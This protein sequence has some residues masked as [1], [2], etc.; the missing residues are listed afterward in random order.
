MS[1][2]NMEITSSELVTNLHNM[3]KL[4]EGWPPEH[5]LRIG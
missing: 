2:P 3:V 1:R 5:R 4:P